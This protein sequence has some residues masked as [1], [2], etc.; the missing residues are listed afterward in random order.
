M[1]DRPRLDDIDDGEAILTAIA[2]LGYSFETSGARPGRYL[3]SDDQHAGLADY[4]V[5]TKGV[6]WMTA[7]AAFNRISAQ[8]FRLREPDRHPSGLA[9]TEPAYRIVVPLGREYTTL[10]R[11]G[12]R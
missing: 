2:G 12:I 8:G 3:E 1:T 11:K 4:L 6:P 5:R 10:S 9:T 7:L